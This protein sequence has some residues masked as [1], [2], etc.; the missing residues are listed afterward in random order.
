MN[1]SNDFVSCPCQHCNGKIEFD[2]KQLDVT[3]TADDAITGQ[4]I[5]CPHCGRD[6][7]LFVPRNVPT[8][9]KP[10]ST[11][12]GNLRFCGDCGGTVSVHAET[13]P[14]CG[15][16]MNKKGSDTSHWTTGRV[17]LLVIFV[18]AVLA[19]LIFIIV[20]GGLL[21]LHTDD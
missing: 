20:Y 15:A 14:H 6:T 10:A 21:G 8:P 5:V 2:A 19:T 11:L 13:C 12:A 7:I 3:G 9:A 4:T 18:A 1:P 17:L 16:P